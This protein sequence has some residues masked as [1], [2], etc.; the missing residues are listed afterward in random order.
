M[1]TKPTPAPRTFS[2]RRF[3]RDPETL[4]VDG[5][6]NGKWTTITFDT[7]AAV[8]V[9]RSNT[10]NC[11]IRPL[12][13]SVN[14]RS[15]TGEVSPVI[16][17]ADIELQLGSSCIHH[18][19]L[20]A[21]IED[22]FIL[23]MDLIRQHGFAFD[24]NLNI[25]KFGNEEFV[26]SHP[27]YR[28]VKILATETV[29][30]PGNSENII[31]GRLEHD[32]GSCVGFVQQPEETNK[33][34]IAKT[35]VKHGNDIP[36]RVANIFPTSLKIS[37]GDV[38]ATYEPISCITS[39]EDSD[40]HRKEDTTLDASKIQENLNHFKKS[41]QHLSQQELKDAIQFI[42]GHIEIFE[43]R[44]GTT[45]RTTLIQHRIDTGEAQPIRQP[46]RRLPMAKQQEVKELVDKMLSEGIIEQSSSPWSAPVVLVTKRDGSTRFCVDYRKL[47]DVTKK[48]SYPLPRI[49]DTLTTLAGSKWFST[50]DLK[51]G[52]W[53]VGI[54]QEDKEK[55]AFSTGDGLYQ[56]T[57][58]PFG[59][60]NAPATFERLMEMVLRGLTWRTCLVYLDDILV[61]GKSFEE[62]LANL[63]EV[64]NRIRNAHLM[65]NPKK[66]SLFQQRVEF[67]GHVV[68]AE[69]IH[70]DERK[71]E[72]VREWPRPQD[73]HQLRSFLGLCTY[74]RRFVEG[75]AD[76]AAPLHK[77]TE[78]K[79]VFVWN[80][81][82]EN[83]FR[84]LK[85]ALC[86]S[87]VLGY[88]QSHG[89]FILDTDASNVGIG[90]VL[91]QIQDGEE[92]VIEYFSRVI[93]KPER[94]YCV[95]RKELLAI[96]RAVDH[97]HKYLYGRK[98][99][100]RTDHA[101]LKWLLRMKNPEG[102]L[103]RWMEKL[104]QYNFEIRHRPGRV[105]KNADALSRRPCPENCKHC[106]K[107]EQHEGAQ[108]VRQLAIQESEEWSREQCRAE[109][110]EDP[111]IGPI[112]RLKEAG[113]ERPSW[114]DISDR[115][116]S[117]KALWAQWASLKVEHGLLQRM[118][119]SADGKQTR[120]QLLVPRRKIPDVLREIHNGSSGAH[121]GVNK[122]LDKVRERFYWV[123]CCEDVRSW[124][125]KCNT[126]ATT[127]GPRT[128][129]RG[130][131][132]KYNVG[133]PFER[134]AIDVAGPFPETHKGNKYILVAMDYFSKWPEAF[135]IPNQ[136]VT[137][138][139]K[140]LVD[141]VFSRFGVPL[142]LHSDQGRNFESK[143]F[144]KMCALMGIKKTR[145]TPLHPQSDGMVERF[146]RT[147]EQ[148]LSK[149]VDKHQRDWD[150]H[151]SIFLMA[152]RSAVHNTTGL[153]PARVLFGR[154]IRLPCDL[155]FGSPREEG[156]EINDYA[157][158]LKEKLLAVHDVARG[159]IAIASDRMKTRYDVK[160][161]S[162][163]FQEGDQ[164]WLY[165]PLRKKGVSPKL[166]P[167]WEG[168]YSVIKRIND[169]VYRIQR[170]PKGKMKVVHLDRLAPYHGEDCSDRDDQN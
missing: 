99:L 150:E 108:V 105:H 37:E 82:S 75:F 87:P 69:G 157:D 147:L 136:E 130:E 50:L 18:K 26:L 124:C 86:S 67:L 93:S 74:Y 66:C 38:I 47:N 55:T 5:K 72:A 143:V 13:G 107:I 169:L 11:G 3:S 117:F 70:T 140:I 164:V 96:V 111:D 142:E 63:Q 137:T 106:N 6:V 31:V 167:S 98:F 16:G 29:R 121:F 23:G 51:S 21:D 39:C 120:A 80:A 8:S 154:E 81:T 165:N 118:W 155:V 170:S 20:V 127:K 9:A 4:V 85:A 133:L 17:Q 43:G 79:S 114:T 33:Y 125:R 40:V 160:A 1:L 56:F 163:G 132:K 52:Y 139:A 34:L 25:L 97:F 65:L 41:W 159:R 92:R 115:G 110:L 102:Q 7:G 30:V 44:N 62:H 53:Q 48:D 129:S 60:C 64:F 28:P 95:T 166:T 59:L 156:Q 161:N 84:R 22:D 135:A 126:C 128:R 113:E 71:I 104:Q 148:H 158:Q 42:S 88:P 168:P 27:R 103:A 91:S 153:T 15:V 49:D 144:Q 141:N 58:M 100:I 109:Q 116:L 19:V 151:L 162:A 46:P 119:E 78:D 123:N 146:N 45:G 89:T 10:I 90:A 152:Y 83:A 138:V 68:T 35:V 36:I 32:P 134:I 149:V 131:L 14:L 94:N 12:N 145:T 57:V 54:R 101:A 73:K 76:I 112:L 77:M 122:T 61:M 2:I 24:H